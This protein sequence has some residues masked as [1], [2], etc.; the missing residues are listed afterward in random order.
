MAGKTKSR[1]AAA[2]GDVERA[3]ARRGRKSK[4]SRFHVAHVGK[5]MTLAVAFALAVELCPGG[6]LDVI[7]LGRYDFSV[8]LSGPSGYSAEQAYAGAC[9]AQSTI[10]CAR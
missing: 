5:D 4:Q 1:V 10:Y 8:W 2:G 7:E 9:T 3:S 6:T